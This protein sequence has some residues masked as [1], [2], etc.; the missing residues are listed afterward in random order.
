MSQ[1]PPPPG[2]FPPQPQYPQ[3]QGYPP[4]PGYPPQYQPPMMPPPNWQAAQAPRTKSKAPV[5]VGIVAA[6]V[7]VGA[8]VGY[9]VSQSGDSG[10]SGSSGALITVPP[11]VAP[12]D[13]GSG[14]NPTGVTLP[15]PGVSSPVEVTLPNITAPT[16]TQAAGGGGGGGAGTVP[17]A[18][19]VPMQDGVSVA[20]PQGWEIY[21][22]N[23]AHVEIGL[24]SAGV[25]ITSGGGYMSAV[26]GVNDYVSSL[27]NSLSSVSTAAPEASASFTA[28]FVEVQNVNYS[29]VYNSSQGGSLPVVGW[30]LAGLR[31]DGVV[32][33]IDSMWV[34]DGSGKPSTDFT[35]GLTTV[36]GSSIL[37]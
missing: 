13:P 20:V 7:V 5:L 14:G 37:G 2:Q 9:F 25:Y 36:L 8:G 19:M 16:T 22:Q 15:G 32:V 23:A 17:V 27:G 21:G 3:Q 6:V 11:P 35:D 4:Q 12:A 31:A 30:V 28:T 1:T 34:N 33:I 29:G 24:G 10:A 26:D 18:S